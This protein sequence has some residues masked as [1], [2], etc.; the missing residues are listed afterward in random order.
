MNEFK[1][2]SEN[3]G[4]A[5]FIQPILFPVICFSAR[6]KFSCDVLLYSETH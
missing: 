6:A 3:V 5:K 4:H 1:G 2:V